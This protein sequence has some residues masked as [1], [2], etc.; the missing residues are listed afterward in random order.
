M[1][2]KRGQFT[3]FVILGIVLVSTFAFLLFARNIMQIDELKERANGVVEDALANSNINFYVKSC[4]DRVTDDAVYLASLQGGRIYESQGGSYPDVDSGSK[5]FDYLPFNVTEPY[6]N[7]HYGILN[8]SY[9]ILPNVNSNCISTN[10]P[11]YPL[12]NTYLTDIL[13]K[14]HINSLI[15]KP[16][17]CTFDTGAFG[18]FALPRLCDE[19]GP[20]KVN[21]TG[22][23]AYQFKTCKG[24]S[25]GDNSIQEQLAAYISN[26]TN[27]CVDFEIFENI[28]YNITAINKPETTVT[29]GKEELTVQTRYPFKVKIG[30]KSVTAYAMFE[31]DKPI[32]LKELYEYIYGLLEKEYKDLYFDIDRDYHTSSGWDNKISVLK[33]T[34]PAWSCKNGICE[35]GSFDDVYQVVDNRSNIRGQP[36]VFNFAIKNRIPALDYIDT[37]FNYSIVVMEGDEINLKPFALDADENALLY[38]YGGWKEDFDDVFDEDCCLANPDDCY[39]NPDKC[40]FESGS[41]VVPNAWTNSQIYLDTEQFANYKTTHADIGLH[42]TLVNATDEEG[43]VDYQEV[44]I[45]V[46]DEPK[47]DAT[48]KNTYED[49]DP[50]FGSIEDPYILNAKSVSF[51]TMVEEYQWDDLEFEFSTVQEEVTIPEIL[52]MPYDIMNIKTLPFTIP[53]IHEIKLK[54][55]YTTPTDETEWTTP[56]TWKVQVENC[57]PHSN[58]GTTPYPY[59][60]LPSDPFIGY[61]LLY[62]IEI[63]PFQADHTCCVNYDYADIECFNYVDYGDFIAMQ[64]RED[65]FR[66]IEDYPDSDVSGRYLFDEDANKIK[67]SGQLHNEDRNN[68]IKREFSRE[69]SG[70][71]GNICSGEITETYAIADNCGGYDTDTYQVE[72]CRG[73]GFVDD[74]GNPLENDGNGL[75]TELEGTK[76]GLVCVNYGPEDLFSSEF[77][78]LLKDDTIKA[79][80]NLHHKFEDGI[81]THG[82]GAENRRLMTELDQP[83]ESFE[84]TYGLDK[85]D[86]GPE[87][88]IPAN[89]ICSSDAEYYYI[90]QN[91]QHP[92]DNSYVVNRED[93][94][95]ETGG[96]KC[97]ESVCHPYLGE[98]ALPKL[99]TCECAVETGCYR[100]GELMDFE[101]MNQQN[102]TSHC[103]SNSNREK[104]GGWCYSD[105]RHWTQDE[106]RQACA[107]AAGTLDYMP[108][109][110]TTKFI[111]AVDNYMKTDYAPENKITAEG[112]FCCLEDDYLARGSAETLF[113]GNTRPPADFPLD[114]AKYL[115]GK[116][117]CCDGELKMDGD[118][119]KDYPFRDGSYYDCGDPENTCKYKDNWIINGEFVL[120]QVNYNTEIVVILERVPISERQYYDTDYRATGVGCPLYPTQQ[121]IC[122]ISSSTKNFGTPDGMCARNTV[123]YT[124]ECTYGTVCNRQGI[125]YKGVD[126]CRADIDKCDEDLSDGFGGRGYETVRLDS[127]GNKVCG[128]P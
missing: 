113:R 13:D 34:N 39:E 56:D 69:C 47:V 122:D 41:G 103:V 7:S 55:K 98:C 42:Y 3:V 111:F 76:G 126:L 46:A 99:D 58:P 36:L 37:G 21:V 18:V 102:P 15:G 54:A 57:L 110:T 23:K 17:T 125:Y 84:T 114:R 65:I 35:N 24:L 25:Y 53:G 107:C 16:Q 45:M 68:V 91:D 115:D 5:G 104:T 87:N 51:F 71:R 33:R 96:Y 88:T 11:P 124:G 70:D 75:L 44:T 116:Q 10:P 121:L 26:K 14:F 95:Y 89:G 1:V 30:R 83:Q 50:S 119:C 43:L 72:L 28:G 49:I 67:N 52:G 48:G 59:N 77:L 85:K 40:V 4:L 82:S 9:G 108:V 100:Y 61:S 74:D 60:A 94:T 62:S 93:I 2:G 90:P 32:L 27:E 79:Y 31:V 81:Y 8:I 63:D 80:Y 86:M 66:D 118:L 73:P 22:E 128:Y 92:L 106:I 117:N 123:T 29:F 120:N 6:N 97:D 112:N 64:D 109:G 105:C 127:N 20:N 12:A 101:F 78:N 38:T 19:E